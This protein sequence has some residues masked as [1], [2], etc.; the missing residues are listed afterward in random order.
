[1]IHQILF[2]SYEL[3]RFVE[4]FNLNYINWMEEEEKQLIEYILKA[5]ELCQLTAQSEQK[6]LYRNFVIC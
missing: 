3:F 1:M 6:G 5:E 4:R 2:R